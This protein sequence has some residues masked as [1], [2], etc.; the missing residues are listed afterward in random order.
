MM[1]GLKS[2]MSKPLKQ[3]LLITPTIIK[4]IAVQV[5]MEDDYELCNYGAT[6]VGFYL[7]LRK[8]NLVP[9]STPQFNGKEQLT[10]GNVALDNELKLATFQIEWSEVMQHNEKELWLVV[11][12]VKDPK[13]CLIRVLDH[14]I[15]Q[16]PAKQANPLFCYRN[17]RNELKTLTYDQLSKQLKTWI[18]RTVHDPA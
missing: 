3:A 16:I 8:S 12:P 17:A 10:R 6:L 18:E 13:I 7:C 1:N 9:I 2:E 11:Y 5:V 14:M 15:Q 4:E